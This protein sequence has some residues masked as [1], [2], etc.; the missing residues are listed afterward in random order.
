[1]KLWSPSGSRAH[2]NLDLSHVLGDVM[3]PNRGGQDSRLWGAGPYC[4]SLCTLFFQGIDSQSQYENR[5]HG[6]EEEHRHTS[7]SWGITIV[8]PVVLTEEPGSE[9]RGN[10]R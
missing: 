9:M 10:L 8:P 7:M 3:H 1:M 2:H 5:R 6:W 4:A